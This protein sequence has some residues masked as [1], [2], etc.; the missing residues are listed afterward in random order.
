[1]TPTPTEVDSCAQPEAWTNG[2]LGNLL[3]RVATA[4]SRKQDKIIYLGYLS[5]EGKM[6]IVVGGATA[7]TFEHDDASVSSLSCSSVTGQLRLVLD[8]MTRVG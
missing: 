2:L 6:S 1:M 5:R 3:R 4:G 8:D 7:Y